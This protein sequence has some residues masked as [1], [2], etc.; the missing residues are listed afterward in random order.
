MSYNSTLATEG[1]Q[2][3]TTLA[4]DAPEEPP[5][6]VD[7]DGTL[8]HCDSLLESCASLARR[9]FEWLLIPFWWLRHGK[10]Y[11]KKRVAL[12]SR[13]DVSRLPYK[14][15]VV[16]ELKRQRRAGRKVILCT[17]AAEELALR[18]AEHLAIF[19][20]VIASDGIVN[21]AGA[22]KRDA[23]VAR[24]GKGGFDYIGDSRRDLEAWTAARKAMVADP[25]ARLLLSLR[26]RGITAAAIYSESRGR[27][28][29]L[30]LRAIRVH[31]W[32]KNLLLFAPLAL[33]HRML[34]LQGLLAFMGFSFVASAGYL[35]NDVLDIEADRKH[36]QKRSRPIASGAISL[37]QV[38]VAIP[39][40]LILGSAAAI[41]VSLS[42][43]GTVGMYFIASMAYSLWL[44]RSAPLD[45]ILLAGLY[46]IRI[47]AGGAAFHIV[48]SPW[49]LAVSVFLFLSLAMVKRVS[50]LR[51][52]ADSRSAPGRGYQRI[53]IEQL[54]SMG[55]AAGYISV[56]VTALYISSPD[57]QKLYAHPHL[58]WLILPIMLYW[59]SRIWLLTG[60]G[61][62]HE[63][64][65]LF[66]IQDKT[67]YI[68]GV[69]GAAIAALATT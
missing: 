13:L 40:L 10:A 64:P 16:D 68:A 46:T 41:D 50:E 14:T 49:T 31:Q 36:S 43:A 8:I 22:S 42:F 37:P 59:I 66:A 56:L 6:C 45:V 53:D 60:R 58:L 34:S 30:W 65:V 67:T 39:L 19:D 33:G 9:S 18:A 35:L 32:A 2:R 21:M 69:L 57:V 15:A 52:L 25:S 51:E 38:L 55:G 7:L 29:N 17:G 5:L 12:L 3:R 20:D 48:I 54:S 24:F 44:K 62:I 11:V 28:L 61:R 47:A 26:R 27:R 63:D 23:L 1:R 4:V